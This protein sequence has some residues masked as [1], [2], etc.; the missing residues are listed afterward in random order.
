MNERKSKQ[1]NAQHSGIREPAAPC[2]R[3]VPGCCAN[4]GP[5][6]AKDPMPVHAAVIGSM[7]RSCV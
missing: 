4:N 1:Q 2:G 7:N 3:T 5:D 6:T